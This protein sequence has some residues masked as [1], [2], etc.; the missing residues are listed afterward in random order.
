MMVTAVTRRAHGTVVITVNAGRI[1]YTPAAELQRAGQ[2]HLH[3]E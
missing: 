3:G 1:T 2:L